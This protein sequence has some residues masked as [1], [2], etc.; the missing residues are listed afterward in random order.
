LP[1]EGQLDLVTVV[2]SIRTLL[3]TFSDLGIEINCCVRIARSC[4]EDVIDNPEISSQLRFPVGVQ[5]NNAILP[6]C[7]DS[8]PFRFSVDGT[9]NR[10]I[11]LFDKSETTCKI[12]RVVVGIVPRVHR[13]KQFLEVDVTILNDGSPNRP[14]KRLSQVLRSHPVDNSINFLPVG[15]PK[16]PCSPQVGIV[17][18]LAPKLLEM[19]HRI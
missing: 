2:E 10:D 12:F 17:K 6:C 5:Q 4:S 13:G 1:K 11:L 14:C 18:G 3:V 9:F 16:T 8:V 7:K 15:T 19:R